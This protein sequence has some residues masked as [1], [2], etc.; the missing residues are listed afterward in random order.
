MISSAII[1]AAAFSI[2]IFLLSLLGNRRRMDLAAALEAREKELEKS[3]KESGTDRTI[4]TYPEIV[5]KRSVIASLVF[6][7]AIFFFASILGLVIAFGVAPGP[8]QTGA[9]MLCLLTVVACAAPPWI[10]YI[11]MSRTSVEITSSGLNRLSPWH[12]KRSITWNE[13]EKVSYSYLLDVYV[14]R[15]SKGKIRIRALL[16]GVGFFLEMMERHVPRR[17]RMALEDRRRWSI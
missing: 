11:G 13:I 1:F 6:S 3:R 8:G 14:I 9:V 5:R 12:R 17:R 4:L 7:V 2:Y 15:T 10:V 16:E